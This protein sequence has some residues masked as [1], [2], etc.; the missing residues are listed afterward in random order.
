MININGT[1]ILDYP[2]RITDKKITKEGKK[3]VEE[4]TEL[5][6]N[7]IKKYKIKITNIETKTDG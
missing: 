2:S 3:R 1:F 6:A 4:L 7:F 5:I